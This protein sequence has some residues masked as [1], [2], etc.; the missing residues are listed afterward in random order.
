MVQLLE[1]DI[2]KKKETWEKER[3]AVWQPGKWDSMEQHIWKEITTVVNTVDVDKQ[4]P[5]HLYAQ[6]IPYT[7]IWTE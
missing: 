7:H 5:F 4:S 1:T 3:S 2:F 6:Y